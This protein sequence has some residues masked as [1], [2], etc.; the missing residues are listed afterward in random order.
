MTH[1]EMDELY[2]LYVLGV[3]EPEQ[4]AEIDEHLGNRCEHCLARLKEAGAVSSAMAAV[5]DVQEPPSGL[6]ERVLGI[7][8][9]AARP[10][11][12]S[13]GWLYAVAGLSAA[14]LALVAYSLS[15]ANTLQ[16]MREQ[17][18]QLRAALDILSRPNTRTV[19]FG[20]AENAPHGKVLIN[21]NGGL[22][23]VGSQLPGLASDKTFELWLIPAQG[24]PR[25]A[26]L[27]RANATGSVVSVSNI[28]VDLTQVKAVAVSI[29]P[30]QGSSAPT[31]TPILIVSLG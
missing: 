4:A 21:Q 31:T 22:V 10:A 25:P 15:A 9:S 28:P 3:L 7:V 8:R 16:A 5:V 23:F 12:R 13:R 19:Q 17:A 6:R 24:A 30:R 26:G 27:F 14:C 20:L 1:P 2:E 11:K 18:N 29:E